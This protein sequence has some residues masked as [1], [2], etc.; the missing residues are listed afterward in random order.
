MYMN[1]TREAGRYLTSFAKLIRH[2]L[3]GSSEENISLD[4]E[5]EALQYY[6]ELQRLRFNDNFDFSIFVDDDIIQEST[7]IPPLFIQPFLENAIEHGLQHKTEK[8]MLKLKIEMQEDCLM[9]EVEDDGIGREKS[10]ELN[11]KKGH[12]HKSMGM[13]I[14]GKRMASLNKIM[15]SKIHLEITDLSDEKGYASGTLVR[16]CIPYKS[17][18]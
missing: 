14:V 12:L 18:W 1:K 13:E 10:R 9:V 16:I 15:N 8:G 7:L 6:L 3:Y 5:I 11:E 17:A 4:K 2:T